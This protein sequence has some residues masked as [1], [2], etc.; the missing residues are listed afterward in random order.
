MLSR[1]KKEYAFDIPSKCKATVTNRCNLK[2]VRKICDNLDDAHKDRFV[3]S[4]FRPLINISEIILSS[5]IVHQVLRRTLKASENDKDAVLFRFGEKEARFGLQ[6]FCLV[7]GFKIAADD[8]NAYEVPKNNSSLLQLFKKKRGMIKRSYLLEKFH[9]LDNEKRRGDEVQIGTRDGL[10]ACCFVCRTVKLFK[11]TSF[12]KGKNPQSINYSLHGFSLAIMIWAFEALPDVGREF[13]Q[14]NI[15]VPF[16]RMYCWKMKKQLRD[17]LLTTFFDRAEIQVRRTLEPSSYEFESSYL[18][19]LGIIVEEEDSVRQDEDEEG[20]AT[21]DEGEG[22]ASSKADD[23]DDVDDEEDEEEEKEEEEE[24]NASQPEDAPQPHVLD[25]EKIANIVRKMVKDEVRKVVKEKMNNLFERMKNEFFEAKDKPSSRATYD[26]PN[27]DPDVEVEKNVRDTETVECDMMKSPSPMSEQE[28]TGVHGFDTGF[29]TDPSSTI[30]VYQERQPPTPIEIEE[31]VEDLES[32]KWK[33]HRKKRKV[34]VLR[35]PPV[36][37]TKLEDLQTWLSSYPESAEV[38]LSSGGPARKVFF[39]QLVNDGWLTSEHVDEA[40][41]H[42]REHGKQFP[43][44]FRQDCAVLDTF[45]VSYVRS[46]F[47]GMSK[48][49]KIPKALCRYAA[50]EIHSN[51]K[52]WTGCTKLYVPFCKEELERQLE[53]IRVVVPMLLAQLN[54]KYSGEKFEYK[55]LTSPSQSNG[56]DCGMFT[57][58]FIEFLHAEKNVEGVDQSRISAWR[59]KLASEIFGAHFDP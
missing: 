43:L 28:M 9:K 24:E 1:T 50:G 25:E 11:R 23:D 12:G 14:T 49:T 26:V 20:T 41:F 48:T 10:G 36:D 38:Q 39:N 52:T 51:G 29:V 33:G 46:F 8:E 32:P 47:K 19:K 44:L 21:K 40:L 13:A 6:E 59:V 45:F 37:P 30:V 55:R 27:D 57:I 18:N 54:A 53:P 58:K 34:V 35:T 16:P 56:F 17:E 31:T 5:Q 4:C 42:I 22:S 3:E 7:T 15:G 2:V